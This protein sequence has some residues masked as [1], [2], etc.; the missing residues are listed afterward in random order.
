MINVKNL[1]KH[2]FSY[3]K[4]PVQALKGISFQIEAG[5]FYTLLGPSGCGKTTTLRCIAGFEDPQEGEI[6]IDDKLVFSSEK[7]V[8]LPAMKRNFG[9]VFQS[10]AIWPHM[11]VFKNVAFPLAHGQHKVPKA[12]IKDRVMRA[13]KLTQLE[14]L[15][16]RPA[17]FLSGGQQQ[18]VALARALVNEPRV[19]LLD[20]PLSNLDAGLREDMRLE[21]RDLSKRL[22]IT[23]LYVTHDQLEALTMSDRVAVMNAGLIVQEGSSLNIYKEPASR[24]VARFIGVANFLEGVVSAES[25]NGWAEVNTPAGIIRCRPPEGAVAGNRVLI[26]IRPEDLIFCQDEALPDHNV[27]QAHLDKVVFTGEALDCKVSVAD[28][29]FRVKV[30]SSI[31][32]EAGS[33]VRF[34]LPPDQCRVLPAS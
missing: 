32:V 25:T 26:I 15:A 14:G 3:D 18:R 21:I 24:F 19:L 31:A 29:K 28:Q 8:D 30:H 34:Y 1:K 17:P 27:I 10:Y 16:D 7:Q 33:N 11:S 20:E 22:N 4:T 12:E 13:L 9:I 6:W 5:E 23:T 2:Y